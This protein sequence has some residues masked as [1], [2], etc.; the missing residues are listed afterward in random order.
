MVSIYL[1]ISKSNM[2]KIQKELKFVR[3]ILTHVRN[4]IL[5]HIRKTIVGKNVI[6]KK[7]TKNKLKSHS[8]SLGI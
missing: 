1:N 5:K 7:K 4:K 2:C 3:N 8:K 6:D